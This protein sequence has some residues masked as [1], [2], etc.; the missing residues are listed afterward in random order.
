MKSSE[1]RNFQAPN[2][3]KV[4]IGRS[5]DRSENG[6]SD[7]LVPLKTEWAK[8]AGDKFPR[9][10]EVTSKLDRGQEAKEDVT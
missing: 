7:D 5:N 8:A 6:I 3:P 2:S 1:D 9:R 4:T 10:R